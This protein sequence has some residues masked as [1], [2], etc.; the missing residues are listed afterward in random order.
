VT[1]HADGFKETQQQV[2][3]QTATSA[4]VLLTLT[5]VESSPTTRPPGSNPLIEAS[6]PTEA[7]KEFEKGRTALIEEKN[8]KSGISHLEKAVRLFPD[9]LQAHLLL[10]TAHIEAGQFEK[11][12][13][14]LQRTLE[15]N[16]NTAEAHFALGEMY[17]Q[18]KRFAEA[19]KSLLEGLNLNDNSWQGHFSLAQT[20]WALGDVNK[21]L[22]H[23]TK[24]HELNPEFPQVHLLMGNL[25]LRQRDAQ[26]ALSEFE[27]YLKRESSGAL[28]DQARQLVKKIRDALESQ[29]KPPN[30]P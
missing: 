12:E 11:G 9:F 13:R 1:V 21:T 22:P 5:P 30:Q 25:F 17:R 7:R 23:A 28:A 24:A 14:E 29:K 19:E 18:Q 8:L 4:N 3:C 10:G 16:P 15:I 6:V 26:R 27:D 20:Y 2:D